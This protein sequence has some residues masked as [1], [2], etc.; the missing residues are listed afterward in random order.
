MR[1]SDW[2]SD[3]CSSDLQ[4]LSSARRTCIDSVSAVEWTATVA[5]PRSRHARWMRSAISPRF[6]IRILRNTGAPFR[7]VGGRCS[8]DDYQRI[9]AFERRDG[10]DEDLPDRAGASHRALVAALSRL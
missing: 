9:A 4:T 2:S 6:A 1:I 5:M 7:N 8:L 3:V 10:C